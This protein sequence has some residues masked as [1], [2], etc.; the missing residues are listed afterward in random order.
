L[1]K[2][3]LAVCGCSFM[4]SSYNKY[5]LIKGSSWPEYADVEFLDDSN[6]IKKEIVNIW[7]YE[8]RLHFTD[9]YIKSKNFDYINLAY[10]GTSNFLIRMQ[11]D[12]AIKFKSDYIIVSA[13]SSDRFEIPLAEF[14]YSRLIRNY[15]NSNTEEHIAGVDNKILSPIDN[16]Y[17]LTIFPSFKNQLDVIDIGVDRKT[18]IKYYLNFLS[19]NNM[20][21]TKHYYII[22]G[23]LDLLERLKI[24]YVFLPGPLKHFDW[25]EYSCWPDNSPQPWDYVTDKN[26]YFNTG[27]HLP[28]NI[29]RE[30]SKTLASITPDW[31]N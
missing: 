15:D 16:N 12:Q 30:L 8:H 14:K 4:T 31:S 10:G 6:I 27:N 25:S 3:K 26:I 18:A 9:L 19:N 13:T 7:Q 5:H 21:D 28:G 1:V 29:H 20:N 24:P 11:I 2:K 22:Q 17:N 23:G